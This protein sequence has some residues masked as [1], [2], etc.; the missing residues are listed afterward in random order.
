[1]EVACIIYFFFSNDGR[2]SELI[3]HARDCLEKDDGEKR[4]F[5][6]MWIAT[7]M[8]PKAHR[9]TN[10]GKNSMWL[11]DYTDNGLS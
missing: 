3:S 6:A 1:M 9:N 4:Y 7:G 10:N 11:S 5:P 8:T 2:N